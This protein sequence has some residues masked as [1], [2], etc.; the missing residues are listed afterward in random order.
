MIKNCQ[1]CNALMERRRD[2]TGY[3][4]TNLQHVRRKYCSH[5]CKVT[6]MRIKVEKE[7]PISEVVPFPHMAR[8]LWTKG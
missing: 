7:L 4:E 1:L 3:L 2:Q 6:A 8:K 5:E